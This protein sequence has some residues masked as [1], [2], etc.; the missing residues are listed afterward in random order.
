MSRRPTIDL[1]RGQWRYL[2]AELIDRTKKPLANVPF[3]LYVV[4]AILILGA[5]GIWAE[6]FQFFEST[7]PDAIRII[8]A[9]ITFFLALIGTAA[10]QLTYESSDDGNKILVAF[11]QFM[12]IAFSM[13][14]VVLIIWL[15][16]ADT[17]NTPIF[18]LTL[19]C[20]LCAVWVWW[21]ANARAKMFD[22]DADASIG[23]PTNRTLDG[24]LEGFR[25]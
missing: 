6:V 23:G 10:V 21:I 25:V 7:K 24:N 15:S 18:L 14:A 13:L 17:V 8:V 3:V 5:L 9:M 20:S 12:L 19:V 11:A 1:S 22:V 16:K 4:I 2:C